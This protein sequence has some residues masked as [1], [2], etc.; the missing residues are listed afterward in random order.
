[1]SRVNPADRAELSHVSFPCPHHYIYLTLW[2]LSL[3]ILFLL[4]SF[5]NVVRRLF[6]G[7]K[8]NEVVFLL[9]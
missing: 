8:K 1:M 2:R 4:G 6:P 9:G 3:L 7:G 5:C